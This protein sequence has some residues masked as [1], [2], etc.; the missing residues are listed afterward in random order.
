MLTFVAHEDVENYSLGGLGSG[1]KGYNIGYRLCDYRDWNQGDYVLR[2]ENDPYGFSAKQFE[3]SGFWTSSDTTVVERYGDEYVEGAWVISMGE[4]EA[5][6]WLV[7]KQNR[8]PIR[9]VM[10]E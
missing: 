5:G 7:K 10:D 8:Y 2:E 1:L 3:L 6:L 4:E 9:C